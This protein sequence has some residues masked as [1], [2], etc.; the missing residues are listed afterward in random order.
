VK[1][2]PWADFRKEFHYNNIMFLAAG[3]A[4]RAVTGKPWSDL[5]RERIL[6]PL[7]MHDTNTSVAIAQK[8]PRLALGYQW[9]ENEGQ[10]SFTHKPMRA[11]DA[12]A[13]AG[14]INSNVVDM[15]RWVRFQLGHG[16]L[17]GKR[18]IS[19]DALRE[20]W[21]QQNHHR[22]AE[23]LRHGLVPAHMEGSERHR[24]RRQHRRLRRRGGDAA[25]I[26]ARVRAVDERHG[27]AAPGRLHGDRVERDARRHLEEG[28]EPE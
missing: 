21:T 23:R 4:M 17:E 25:R 19:E 2:E 6:E 24:A 18:L 3:E 16:E 12:I 13:P 8:D 26:E 7:G 9:D 10:G 5:L 11:L 14:A 1:A 28:S 15:A 27:H 20:T 22:A